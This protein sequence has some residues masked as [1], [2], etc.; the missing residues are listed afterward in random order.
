MFRIIDG[1][2]PVDGHGGV[3]MPIWGDALQVTRGGMDET[4]VERK[5]ASLT[6]FLWTIQAEDKAGH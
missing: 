1:R 3:E 5:I 6:H 2:D 4:E